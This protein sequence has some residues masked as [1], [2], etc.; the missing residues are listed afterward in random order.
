MSLKLWFFLHG[1]VLQ[2]SSRDLE[3]VLSGWSGETA[4]AGRVKKEKIRLADI[5]M[6]RFFVFIVKLIPYI[7]SH[8]QAL[9]RHK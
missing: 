1:A 6:I 2:Y 9:P 7:I 4:K 3:G 5:A 8:A